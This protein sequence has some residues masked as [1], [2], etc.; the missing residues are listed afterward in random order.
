MYNGQVK[1]TVKR[2]LTCGNVSTG[3]N[4]SLWLRILASVSGVVN[5]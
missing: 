1:R 2:L 5:H 3:E 4:F